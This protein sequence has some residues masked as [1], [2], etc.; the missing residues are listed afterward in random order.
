M[1][2][3]RYTKEEILDFLRSVCIM[4]L[5]V[6][7]DPYPISTYLLFSVDNDF[8]FYFITHSGSKKAEAI[9][10]KR[11]V[12]FSVWEHNKM[13]IQAHGDCEK[14]AGVEEEKLIL[15][16]IAKATVNVKDFW[17]P[18]L[19]IEGDGYSCYKIKTKWIR[20]L[21]LAGSSI[22]EKD[23]PFTEYRF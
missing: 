15:D 17:P 20:S 16:K 1:N 12:S 21:D 23:I 8:T 11:E 3:I 6:N 22:K 2:T 19:K 9:D 13:L 5:S 7:F 4:S 14:V 18:L 10:K